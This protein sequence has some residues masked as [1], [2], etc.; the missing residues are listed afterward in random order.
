[1]IPLF[2]VMT[3]FLT[4]KNYSKVSGWILSAQNKNDVAAWNWKWKPCVTNEG[5]KGQKLWKDITW[6]TGKHL[7]YPIILPSL[8]LT[9]RLSSKATGFCKWGSVI[10]GEVCIFLASWSSQR[11][12]TPSPCVSMQMANSNYKWWSV[13]LTCWIIA[14]VCLRV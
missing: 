14:S 4:R 9:E 3:V 2:P 13:H 11:T 6:T 5:Y 8:I 7:G 12:Q 1:M 10:L